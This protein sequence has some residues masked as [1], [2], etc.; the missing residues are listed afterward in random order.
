MYYIN[1]YV[2]LTR[3]SREFPSRKKK[4][5]TSAIRLAIV[6]TADPIK[7][8]DSITRCCYFFFILFI[9]QIRN[10]E[11]ES[12]EC[13]KKISRVHHADKNRRDYWGGIKNS[14][15]A[16]RLA[17]RNLYVYFATRVRTVRRTSEICAIHQVRS[18]KA[19]RHN[20]LGER[21]IE[22]KPV[23]EQRSDRI[24]QVDDTTESKVRASPSRNN[25]V[26]ACAY[27]SQEFCLRVYIIKRVIRV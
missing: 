1:I 13:P 5:K 24:F 8:I 4:I 9:F 16:P 12:R 3:D 20:G 7:K 6:A 22:R 26:R 21:R 17:T 27:R 23:E 10:K 15:R 19:D 2:R 18:S 11:E 25:H 14:L